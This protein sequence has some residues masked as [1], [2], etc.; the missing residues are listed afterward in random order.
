MINQRRSKRCKIDHKEVA[1]NYCKSKTDQKGFDLV[2]INDNIGYGVFTTKTFY[3]EEF[4]LE[5]PGPLISAALGR[6]RQESYS[7]HHG[8][9]LFFYNNT[10]TNA[11]RC[12]ILWISL[13]T[14]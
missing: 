13:K 5:Y 3:K 1:K 7:A 4:L 2:Y 6:E 10:W 12:R 11:L 8:S 9:Y 14:R